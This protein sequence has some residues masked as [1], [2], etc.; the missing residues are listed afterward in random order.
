MGV[1][2]EDPASQCRTPAERSQQQFRCGS[3]T[4]NVSGGRWL[5]SLLAGVRIVLPIGERMPLFGHLFDV[6]VGQS[7]LSSLQSTTAMPHWC[8]GHQDTVV[9]SSLQRILELPPLGEARMLLL[10]EFEGE[11]RFLVIRDG[12][13]R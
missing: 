7:L 11:E 8:R 10:R 3:P 1:P 2:I 12:P 9:V 6:V 13:D 4:I 5:M